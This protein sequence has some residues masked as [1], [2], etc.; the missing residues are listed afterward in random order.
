[1]ADI[2][3]PYLNKMVDKYQKELF[4]AERKELE[5]KKAYEY[6]TEYKKLCLEKLDEA[7]KQK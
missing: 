4:V 2:V 5:A 6:A 3:P 7:K 1:M